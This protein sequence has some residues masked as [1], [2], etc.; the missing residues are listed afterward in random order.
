MPFSGD[1]LKEDKY[2]KKKDTKERDNVKKRKK[3]KIWKEMESKIVK[4]MQ[5]G[6]TSAHVQLH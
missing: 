1:N 5:K 3:K 4:Y 6:E 2:N